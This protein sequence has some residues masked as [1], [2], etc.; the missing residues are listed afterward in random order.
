MIQMLLRIA[1]CLILAVALLIIT[2]S[3]QEKATAPRAEAEKLYGLQALFDGSGFVR[4]P[5]GEFQMGSKTGADDERPV[6]R[7]RIS[8]AFELGKFEVTQAQW[9]AVMQRP[10]DAH[11]PANQQPA[12]LG[13]INP[14]AN[15]SHFKGPM[16]PVENIS[17]EDVQQFL[18][19]INALDKQ[20]QYR[21]PTEAEWEYACRASDASAQADNLDARAWYKANADGR[22]HPVGQKQPN[23]WGLYDM[24]GNVWEWVQD[25]Y[26]PN[27]YARSA[28]VDPQ[29]PGPA[30]YKV[31]RGG[32]WYGSAG[33]CRASLRGLDSPTNHYYSLGFRLVRM[34]K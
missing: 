18:Q 1:S 6:H 10:P 19:R 15:P 7:V 9:E 29:G 21:L 12:K 2:S 11:A 26:A 20:H 22:T 30:A 32:S 34:A 3:A 27:Y 31:Y 16:L 8:R 33:D 25:W 28:A 5:A 17:W 14:P 24:Q 4:I 23:A 13:T